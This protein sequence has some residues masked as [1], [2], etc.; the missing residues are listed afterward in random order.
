MMSKIQLIKM[1]V[2]ILVSGLVVLMSRVTQAEQ[3]SIVIPEKPT[4]HLGAETI[5]QVAYSPDGK[6][7]AVAGNGGIRLYDS[8]SLTEVGLLQGHA[9]RGVALTF[10]PDGTWLASVG[11]FDRTIHLWDVESQ[12]QIG[13]LQGHKDWVWCLTFNSNGRLLAS[14]SRD[15]TIRLWDVELQKQV[16]LLQGHSGEVY[17][18]A[19]SPNG[20]ILASGGTDNIIR[21]WDVEL[22]KQVGLLQGHTGWVH[23]IAFSPDGKMLASGGG[24]GDNTIRLWDV[25]P[26]KQTGLLTGHGFHEREKGYK[27]ESRVHSITFSPDGKTLA[28]G[29]GDNTVRLWD[30]ESQQQV[31]KLLTY[32]GNSV[33]SVAFSP[34]GKILVAAGGNKRVNFWDVESRMLQ[35]VKLQLGHTDV[36]SIAFSP[37]GK[38]LASGG[39]ETVRLWDVE[40][41]Q[42]VGVLPEHTGPVGSIT[43]SPDGKLLVSGV[44]YIGEDF[45]VAPTMHYKVMCSGICLWDIES[46][47]QVGNLQH[48]SVRSIAFSPDG[49]SLTSV[50]DGWLD[51][52]VRLWD[53]ESQQQMAVLQTDCREC[54]PA[55]SS[56]GK[57]LALRVD[58][59]VDVTI[60][61]WNI[62]SQQEAGTLQ[63]GWVEFV[64]FSPDG[65][66][67][68]SGGGDNT[69]RLWDVE[70]QQQV[71]TLQTGWVDSITF[72]PDGKTLAAV[73]AG[74]RW[75]RGR[76]ISF[77][78]VESQQRVGVL[79][80]YTG[81]VCSIA[82][83]S[84]GKWLASGD[85]NG[86]ILLWRVSP[87]VVGVE[88]KGKMSITL[89]KLKHTVLLQNFPNP[90]NPETWIPFVLYEAVDMEIR[91]YDAAGRLV[92][93]LQFGQKSPGIYLSK[94]QAAYWDGKNSVGEAVGS[95]VYFYEMRAGNETFVRKALLLK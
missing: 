80:G 30:V 79:Q 60:R 47:Q 50:G 68:A 84:D 27:T 88:P 21:L 37:D 44:G 18:V 6:L 58:S 8:D 70:S 56:D 29:G 32:T 1:V 31:G 20:K 91:I 13:L 17:T 90:F 5:N 61:L 14:G 23:S 89:G 28:S 26:Q 57:W 81:R 75:G 74:A 39:D 93:T 53:V 78:D 25:K 55:L 24:F 36:R 7:V 40:S 66:T 54:S 41:Q 83:S 64:T 76:N 51:E 19:F 85:R 65:K 11:G 22:Q 82:F 16:G 67:L 34:D 73:V 71:G 77:W 94:E 9:N 43:F 87:D 59:G 2:L 12:K 35:R 95:G 42:Q 69:V 45:L 92:R 38:M 62:E 72:S 46:Q 10:S 33:D 86:T 4:A 15:G 3:Q 49:R 63:T 52:T 48:G